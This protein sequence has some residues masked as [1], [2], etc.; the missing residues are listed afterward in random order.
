MIYF[1]YRSFGQ[2]RFNSF[3]N[4]TETFLSCKDVS[5]PLKVVSTIKYCR[6]FKSM[7]QFM[8]TGRAKLLENN[9]SNTQNIQ[10]IVLKISWLD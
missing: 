6:L 10:R 9:T 8:S 7:F 5:T 2:M 1:K 3:N 4:I